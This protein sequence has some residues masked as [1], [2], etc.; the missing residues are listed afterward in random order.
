MIPKNGQ[1]KVKLFKTLRDAVN[2]T[3]SGHPD[4][5]MGILWSLTSG[6]IIIKEY[7]LAKYFRETPTLET[8]AYCIGVSKNST[9]ATEISAALLKGG[10]TQW[11]P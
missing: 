11:V 4:R 1:I 3:I 8:E 5:P 7:D 10:Y 2:E 9:R 6:R